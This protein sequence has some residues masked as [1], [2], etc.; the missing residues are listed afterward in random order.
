MKLL[1]TITGLLLSLLLSVPVLADTL[2]QANVGGY[3]TGSGVGL[4]GGIG[5]AGA[6]YSAY[7]GGYYGTTGVTGVPYSTFN[8]P[9]DSNCCGCNNCNNCGTGYANRC[10]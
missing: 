8:Y 10:Q 5:P 6:P 1:Y 2:Y 7:V 3:T 9:Y 4:G